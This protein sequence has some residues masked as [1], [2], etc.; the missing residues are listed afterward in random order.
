[1]NQG[2]SAHSSADPEPVEIGP[3]TEDDLPAIVD[4]L[5]Y[6]IV[7]SN[8]TLATQPTSVA[9]RLDWFRRFS[10]TGP[11]RLLAAPQA[12]LHRGRYVSRVRRQGRSVHQLGLD[13]APAARP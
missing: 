1:M 4:I 5:N 11:C 6:A 7:N 10:P 13:G 2:I 8:A 3:G 12:R 9:E